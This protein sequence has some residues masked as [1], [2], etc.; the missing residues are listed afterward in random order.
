MSTPQI[1]IGFTEAVVLNYA[2]FA[3]AE[4]TIIIASAD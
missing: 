2:T 4:V 1:L 3:E